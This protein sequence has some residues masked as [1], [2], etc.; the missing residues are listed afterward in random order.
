MIAA[1]PATWR[2]TCAI[3]KASSLSSGLEGGLHGAH[4]TKTGGQLSMRRLDAG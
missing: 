2:A 4:A 3:E 1:D